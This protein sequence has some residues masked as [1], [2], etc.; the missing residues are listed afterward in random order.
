MTESHNTPAPD[1][2]TSPDTAATGST[3][4]ASLSA[5][6][7]SGAATPTEEGATGVADPTV[8]TSAS[9]PGTTGETDPATG[10]ATGLGAASADAPPP[11]DPDV[12]LESGMPSSG[13]GT[14]G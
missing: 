8:S 11:S 6:A 3:P 2:G 13:A 7:A 10:G 14:T 5:D 4:P 12:T 9:T 1:P